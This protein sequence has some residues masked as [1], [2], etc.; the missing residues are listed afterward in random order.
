VEAGVVDVMGAAG[1]VEG[2]RL[3]GAGVVEEGGVVTRS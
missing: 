1:V 3:A 2:L